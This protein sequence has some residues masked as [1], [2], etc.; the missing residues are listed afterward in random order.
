LSIN[1]GSPLCSPFEDILSNCF[2][3]VNAFFPSSSCSFSLSISLSLSLSL[4]IYIYIYIYIYHL[5][6]VSFFLRLLLREK[7][8]SLCFP[9]NIVIFFSSIVYVLGNSI[10]SDFN[11]QGSSSCF[12]LQVQ[13]YW[14]SFALWFSLLWPITVRD[15]FKK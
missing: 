3:S 9:L 2:M 10:Y 13:Q 1:L 12:M 15:F 14:L 7:I 6:F 4:Y 5:L 11:R 8:M